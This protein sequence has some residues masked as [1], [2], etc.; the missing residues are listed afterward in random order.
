M[1]SSFV[2][3]LAEI[4]PWHI[5]PPKTKQTAADMTQAH[6]QPCVGLVAKMFPVIIFPSLKVF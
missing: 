4:V 2:V 5:M 1:D 3:P 6:R